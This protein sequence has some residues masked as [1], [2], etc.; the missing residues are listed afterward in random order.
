MR[1]LIVILAVGWIRLSTAEDS[2][3]YTCDFHPSLSPAIH[4]IL[5]AVEKGIWSIPSN[6]SALT[7]V[8]CLLGNKR[9]DSVM[10]IPT[11]GEVPAS[12]PPPN[13]RNA[14][15]QEL[16][17]AAEKVVPK[18]WWRAGYAD[19]KL[20]L[21]HNHDELPRKQ[22]DVKPLSNRKLKNIYHCVTRQQFMRKSFDFSKRGVHMESSVNKTVCVAHQEPVVMNFFNLWQQA[23][24]D[25]DG[26]FTEVDGVKI[27]Y[28]KSS[29][30]GKL[31][32]AASETLEYFY[33]NYGGIWTGCFAFDSVPECR[34]A[35]ASKE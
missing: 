2:G 21:S 23:K 30:S 20:L 8:G 11:E 10:K 17:T 3:S 18:T 34:G 7:N 5:C 1:L 28:P 31:L 33:A 4:S 29:D 6:T 16:A 27:W 26:K 14:K 19:D 12:P 32:M 15:Y 9:C 22:F 24:G 25:L 35:L 13:A